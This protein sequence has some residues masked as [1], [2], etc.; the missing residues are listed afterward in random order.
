VRWSW[1]S[2]M[3]LGNGPPAP[4]GWRALAHLAL[5]HVKLS[6]LVW[7][8]TQQREVKCVEEPVQPGVI[9]NQ[10]PALKVSRRLRVCDKFGS[11]TIWKDKGCASW[12]PPPSLTHTYTHTHTHTHTHD[13]ETLLGFLEI[14]TLAFELSLTQVLHWKL[15]FSKYSVFE[16]SWPG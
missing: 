11:G 8:R 10:G 1:P 14:Q 6:P 16:R 5:S 9:G 7:D 4:E 13:K 2:L 3:M 12:N 15:L